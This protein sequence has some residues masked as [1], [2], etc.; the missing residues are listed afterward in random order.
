MKDEFPERDFADFNFV[1]A[2]FA[3][4][5][6]EADDA[7]AGVVRRAELGV[8]GTAHRDD[9][10]HMAKRLDVVDD[11]RALVKAEHGR[12]IRRLDARV[13]TLA[14]EGFDEPGFLTANVGARAAMNVEFE[15]VATTED[16]LTKEP[17]CLRLADGTVQNARALV[18]LATDVNVGEVNVVRVAGNDEAFQQLVRIFVNDL[19]V[20]ECAWLGFVG[21]ADEINGLAAFAIHEAPFQTAG[22][23]RAAMYNANLLLTAQNTYSLLQNLLMWT[24]T[25][26]EQISFNPQPT[27]LG[28][29][30]AENVSSGTTIAKSKQIEIINEAS[31][32]ILIEAD[33]QMINLI[34]RNLIS[35]SIKFS[36]NQGVIK[37]RSDEDENQVAISVIDQGTGMET[38]EISKLFNQYETAQRPGTAGESGTGLGLIIC[39]EFV[40]YHK[41]SISVESEPGKGCIFKVTLPKKQ[42]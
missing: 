27:N 13:G 14:F 32:E 8:F 30:I 24:R 20:L 11:G 34:L 42:G 26:T 21:V 41:G 38:Q 12:E 28:D 10:L 15:I 33:L 23:T 22:N 9:V 3:N 37:I 31:P 2:G 39:N 17:L 29:L 35:N 40:N 4:V 19:P 5:A 1:I 6:A 7:R 25:Q 36:F 18:H 16:I